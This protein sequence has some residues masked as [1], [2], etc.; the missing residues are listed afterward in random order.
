MGRR[1]ALTDGF[2]AFRLLVQ[3]ALKKLLEFLL[4]LPV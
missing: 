2:S 3:F 4:E 1:S